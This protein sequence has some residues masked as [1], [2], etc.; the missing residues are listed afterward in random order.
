MSVIHVAFGPNGGRVPP[1]SPPRAPALVVRT[2]TEKET[3]RLVGVPVRALRK[4]TRRR[5]SFTFA[6]VAELRQYTKGVPVARD[7]VDERG[8]GLLVFDAAPLGKLIELPVTGERAYQAHRL[9]TEASAIDDDPERQGEAEDLY[10]RALALDPSLAVAW[11]NLGNIHHR[12]GDDEGANECYRQA[13]ALDP[14]QPEALYNRGYLMLEAGDAARAVPLFLAA[15][16]ADAAFADAH[17]NLA[18][19]FEQMGERT[20]ARTHWKRYLEIEPS[21]TWAEIARSHL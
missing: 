8:Q 17:F 12:R 15:I 2:F 9:Y 21:G 6:E 10:R 4:L 3:A 11:T 19:A 16:D 14:R 7:A 5:S 13:L 18:M 20:K 1:A